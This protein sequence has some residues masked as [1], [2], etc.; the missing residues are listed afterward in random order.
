MIINVGMYMCVSLESSR[1]LSHKSAPQASYQHHALSVMSCGT[2]RHLRGGGTRGLVGQGPWLND[3]QTH[4]S[5]LSSFWKKLRSHS[6]FL[7]LTHT[8]TQTQIINHRQ[9]RAPE[10]EYPVVKDPFG[11]QHHTTCF[12]FSAFLLLKRNFSSDYFVVLQTASLC[13]CCLKCWVR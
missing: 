11:L 9:C 6:H 1:P 4:K 7:L 3:S 10:A 8:H 5:T 2:K 12:Y 13:C